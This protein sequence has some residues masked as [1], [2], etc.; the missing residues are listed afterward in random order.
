MSRSRHQTQPYI[1]L[2]KI[3]AM[4]FMTID[5]IGY[6]FFPN[7]I[8]WRVIG[9]LAA[10]IFTYLI[11]Q[12]VRNTSNLPLYVIRLLVLAFIYQI[13]LI[14]TVSQNLV[15][16][17]IIFNFIGLIILLKGPPWAKLV[18]IPL[19]GLVS[20]SYGWWVLAV[21][22]IY[23]VVK[24]TTLQPLLTSGATLIFSLLSLWQNQ[25]NNPIDYIQPFACLSFVIIWLTE[26]TNSWLKQKKWLDFCLPKYLMYIYFPAHWLVLFLISQI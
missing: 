12:G 11:V 13:I 6:F 5:H 7:Q 15:E 19:Y 14:L 25:G 10:P 21:G 20:I 18:L 8:G 9:R 17:D 26:K 3:L 4:V 22:A 24:S 23:Y 16:L 2:L 1:N